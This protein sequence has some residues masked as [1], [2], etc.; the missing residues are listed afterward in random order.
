MTILNCAPCYRCV[1]GENHKNQTDNTEMQ[2]KFRPAPDVLSSAQIKQPAE[3]QTSA[4]THHLFHSQL[5]N[6]P[7]CE[8]LSWCRRQVWVPMQMQ[9][10][11][12]EWHIWR[13]IGLDLFCVPSCS[14]P[15]STGIPAG[16]SCS[17]ETEHLDT[18]SRQPASHPAP[19]AGTQQ[20]LSPGDKNLH[21]GTSFKPSHGADY[22]NL[23]A[24]FPCVVPWEC[25]C[26]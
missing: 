15:S 26:Y 19:A 8:T 18:S 1:P 25:A 21:F 7:V 22:Q 6:S 14:S 24:Q 17:E 12:A 5:W 20:L 3:N 13:Q 2:N 11:K 16:C 4:P 9:E 23:L 10:H